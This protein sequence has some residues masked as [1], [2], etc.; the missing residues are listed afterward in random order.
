MNEAS[1]GG[2]APYTC[3]AKGALPPS[4]PIEGES[5]R[6]YWAL[7]AFDAPGTYS[8][9]VGWCFKHAAFLYDTNGDMVSDAP[10][11]RC[12]TLTTGD[13]V[14]P[15]GNPPHNDAQYFWCTALPQIQLRR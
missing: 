14:P 6:Y 11:P 7:E 15:I 4:D 3:E 9:S 13:L 2:V 8:N 1:E 5:C 12:V 10:F